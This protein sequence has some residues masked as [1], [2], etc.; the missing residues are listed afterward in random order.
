MVANNNDLK[1]I[2][3]M[4]QIFASL[5]CLFAI[6]LP[7]VAQQEINQETQNGAEK[8]QSGL[9]SL[10]Q[11]F[12]VG[13]ELIISIRVGQFNYGEVLLVVGENGL[14]VDP[15][16]FV[17]VL[18]FPIAKIQ[19]DKPYHL[20]GWFISQDRDFE[21]ILTNELESTSIGTVTAG[22][23]STTID[24][25]KY[26]DF[27][28][29]QLIDLNELASWFGFS[30]GFDFANLSIEI[31][32]PVPLPAQAKL[33]RQ[34]R[35]VNDREHRI[36][37]HPNFDFGYFGRSHQILDATINGIFTNDTTNSFYSVVGVQDIAN[38]SARF[39]FRGT[40]DELL[41]D[42]NLSFRR[43]SVEGGLLGSL[44]ANTIEFG[45]I[46]APRVGGR[47][48]G[49]AV[50]ININ[51][52][53]L[54]EVYDFEFTNIRGVV[55]EA[56]D[57]ELYQNG[58]LIRSEQ[59]V[60]GGQYEFIDV[61]LLAELNTFEIVKY[62]PQGQIERER[63]ERNVDNQIFDSTLNYDISLTRSNSTLF[64]R[65]Q[66]ISLGEQD[67]I[68]SGDY[69]YALSRWFS[70]N[71]SHNLNLS[72][73][74]SLYSV[75]VTTRLSPRVITRFNTNFQNSDQYGFSF[76]LQSR[77]F[78]QFVN[79]NVVRNISFGEVFDS[80]SIRMTGNLFTNNLLRLSYSNDANFNEFA[81]GRSQTRLSNTLTL[82][83]GLGFVS[84]NI[85]RDISEQNQERE[86]TTTGAFTVGAVKGKLNA[87]LNAVYTENEEDNSF[88]FRSIDT[89][90]NYQFTN[91]LSTRASLSR[92]LLNELDAYELSLQWQ[93]K[94]FAVFGSV[95]QTSNNDTSANLNF[96]FSLSETP[97]GEGYISSG[98]PL[99]SNA[100][101]AVRVFE[102]T[103]QN[104][105]FD[106]EDRPLPDVKISAEQQSRFSTTDEDGI[107][108]L[109]D[110]ASFRPTD[111]NIDLDSL[112]DPYL[113]Q[114]TINT[115]ITPRDGLLALI[116]YPLV[117][118]IEIEGE[119]AVFDPRN[120]Q[121]NNLRN[122]DVEI[123]RSD[124]ELV[125][126]V[127]SEF[128]GYF[129]SGILYPGIYRIKISNDS[130]AQNEASLEKQIIVHATKAGQFVPDVQIVASKLNFVDSFQPYI[131]S[132]TN[133]QIAKT[134]F[135]LT[136][137][138]LKQ[139]ALSEELSIQSNKANTQF[140]IG[141][142][143]YST[144]AQ[145]ARICETN[146]QLFP[147][148]Q[149]RTIRQRPSNQFTQV[150]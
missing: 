69:R 31:Y 40:Q 88:E 120:E 81:D 21:L 24:R 29:L 128:D 74:N 43:Q 14:F 49:Q 30:I 57:V 138:K 28:G 126:I 94:N 134:F 36:P 150:R 16:E 55:Q 102:D 142:A 54:G 147:D 139:F 20:R 82:S 53:R 70:T 113:L 141:F 10:L 130:L 127:K 78:E 59:N 63:T 149:V 143:S 146:K 133:E 19:S 51:N 23:F 90:V 85:F 61:P 110:I 132:F 129:Y 111:L 122:A 117:Q 107:A 62:G 105:L 137:L 124:G 84:H 13:E 144:T 68:L 33:D 97:F 121:R 87:R 35:Q 71:F 100:I 83:S 145:A 125:K 91:N 1:L 48:G 18:D 80:A 106:A 148:C 3:I 103:N 112:D 65:G 34:K 25:D 116:N 136:K 104:F 47:T 38:L 58:V 9:D 56:W 73:G 60:T 39:F 26:L 140:Y 89:S 42:A 15:E 12:T 32:S 118:G 46:R 2:K 45:D 7:V 8:P 4:R 77:L 98:Q 108:L 37:K 75:G 115:S 66:V 50:G 6:I 76:S 27:A 11:R 119:V 64:D 95:R 79:A 114:S 99:T 86:A 72:G 52:Q 123:Y 22:D 67:I 131:A 101:V 96:R 92:S 17:E 41:Q 5:V 135:R 44:N 93:A 109:K